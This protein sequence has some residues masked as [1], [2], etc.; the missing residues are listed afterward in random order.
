M[1]AADVAMPYAQPR[2][3]NN[4]RCV[5]ADRLREQIGVAVVERI[6]RAQQRALVVKRVKRLDVECALGI[7][8]RAGWGLGMHDRSNVLL[9]QGLCKRRDLRRG[10]VL[11]INICD[12]VALGDMGVAEG[13]DV[14]AGCRVAL[15]QGHV[16]ELALVLAK[17]LVV[18]DC[19]VGHQGHKA[20]HALLGLVEQHG[21]PRRECV[22]VAQHIVVVVGLD[23]IVRLK[24]LLHAPPVD[25]AALHEAR[26][27]TAHAGDGRV[28]EPV[29]VVLELAR[30]VHVERKLICG[31]LARIRHQEEHGLAEALCDVEDH[32]HAPGEHCGHNHVVL[33][34]RGAHLVHHLDAVVALKVLVAD[35]SLLPQRVCSLVLVQHI[36]EERV[37]EC[38]KRN[39]VRHKLVARTC[40]AEHMQRVSVELH[41]PPNRNVRE[42]KCAAAHRDCADGVVLLVL[43]VGHERFGP[44]TQI[45]RR[46]RDVLVCNVEDIE[47]R[48]DRHKEQRHWKV[49]IEQK[50]PH[51]TV[52]RARRKELFRRRLRPL[53]LGLLW[54]LA[55]AV[56][57]SIVHALAQLAVC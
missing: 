8:G 39:I 40:V 13:L 51:G 36:L 5:L 41:V 50:P 38:R 42:R 56:A 43:K 15:E 52:P 30:A 2:R 17:H 14:L 55:A 46:D 3:E 32:V 33:F 37:V 10:R 6:V 22:K 34:H 35:M 20:V 27:Q 48:D 31:V 29:A 4:R 19:K 12:A 44:G 23:Q 9:G 21:R 45:A 57:R 24:M 26:D 49:V 25:G 28:V 47:T 53:P 16:M 18:V 1:L 11:Q 7:P 54:L